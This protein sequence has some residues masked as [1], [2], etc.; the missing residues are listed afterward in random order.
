MSGMDV[1]DDLE[2]E[3]R[4]VRGAGNVFFV[5]S[6]AIHTARMSGCH[7]VVADMMD[8]KRLP[9]HYV[10]SLTDQILNV[11]ELDRL[12]DYEECEA[13][14]DKVRSLAEGSAPVYCFLRRRLMAPIDPAAVRRIIKGSW[15][16]FPSFS[17]FPSS[18][19]TARTAA[20]L[21]RARGKRFLKRLALS[22][23]P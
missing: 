3:A 21:K 14:L 9:K 11:P 19:G 8:E 15:A 4:E 1:I 10:L 18:Q 5:Y 17:L 16:A 20:K 2:A 23:Q 13:Y 12:V 7:S 22:S 6:Y